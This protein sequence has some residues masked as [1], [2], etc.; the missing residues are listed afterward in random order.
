MA[1]P[2]P[3]ESTVNLVPP[4]AVETEMLARELAK[5]SGEPY[6]SSGATPADA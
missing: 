3:D 5:A 6:D 1:V 2:F 4:D